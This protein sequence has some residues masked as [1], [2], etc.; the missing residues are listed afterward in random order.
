MIQFVDM[1]YVLAAP[2]VLPSIA[3]KVLLKNKYRNSLKG[4]LGKQLGATPSPPNGEGE[5]IWIHAV[6]V[7]EVVAAAALIPELTR[8]F[9]DSRIIAST[10][11][12]TGQEKAQKSLSVADTI[13]YYPLDVSWIVRKFLDHFRPTIFIM[14]ETELW[15]NFL[16]LARERGVR[17]FLA[18]G[19]LSPRSFR[20]YN[21]FKFL[22]K[23][24]LNGVEAFLM[25]T[26]A[27]GERMAMLCGRRDKV[28]VTG[29]CKFDSPGAP[30][31]SKTRQTILD[32]WKIAP[33][34]LII[35]AG[36]T[37]PGEEE[38]ILSA[39]STLK[40]RFPSL[41]LILAP[42]HPERFDEVYRLIRTKHLSGSRASNPETT[43]PDVL[44]LDVMGELARIYGVGLLAIVGGSFVPIGGHNLLEAAIHRIPVLYGPH[45]HKQPEITE[46]LRQTGGGLQITA[47]ALAPTISAL[48]KDNSRR[49]DLGQRAALAVEQ[50]KG[51][52]RRSAAIIKGILDHE[53]TL[54]GIA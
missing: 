41:H 31:D 21:R 23:R 53:P 43:N 33:T 32:Q 52:A 13:T 35:V 28:F 9:P 10:I 26:P 19:R 18:N 27:D 4:M 37:H 12:E 38:L 14:M 11:T 8:I 36:S 6:S 7:G 51:S 50:N 48:L 34:D 2:F 47:S 1:L 44:L 42:R 46:I 29:N 15:P 40:S 39:F 22:F 30:L 17:I 49:S 16:M 24:S 20:L 54:E 3:Y 45:M 5:R 25:Q